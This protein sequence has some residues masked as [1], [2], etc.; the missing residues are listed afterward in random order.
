[1]DSIVIWETY[2][3]NTMRVLLAACAVF[4]LMATHVYAATGTVQGS[5]IDRGTKQP[6]QGATVVLEA[7]DG[8]TTGSRT[9]G[10]FANKDGS[11]VIDNVPS[12]SWRAIVTFVGYK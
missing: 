9:Y 2:G 7:V 8:A 11:Y 10:A 1:M 12:G 5:V 4:A 3:D 6:L